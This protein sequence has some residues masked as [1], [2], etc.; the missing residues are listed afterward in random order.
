MRIDAAAAALEE[1]QSRILEMIATGVPLSGVLHAIVQQIESAAPDMLA[2]IELLDEDGVHLR[3]GAA[4]RLPGAYCSAIDGMP[5]GP[6]AGSC[7]TAMQSAATVVVQDIDADPLW[8]D[9]RALARE[10]GLRACWSTPILDHQRRVLGSFAL[11]FRKPGKPAKRHLRLIERATHL[12]AIALANG[13]AERERARLARELGEREGMF[14]SVFENS[15]VGVTVVDMHGTLRHCNP[16]FARMLGRPQ[17]ELVGRS[18]SEFTHAD[19][20]EPNMRLYRAL[21]AGEIAHFRMQKRYVRKD[22]ELVWVQ[23]NVSRVPAQGETPEQLTIGMMEDITARKRAEESLRD[24]EHRFRTLAEYSPDAIL[25]HQDFRIVF[26]NRA[27]VDLMRAPNAAALVGRPSTFMLPPGYEEAARL[28]S[29]ALYAGEAQPRAEQVY[30]R[31][32]GS[33]VEVEI[34]AAPVVVEGRPAAQ[35]TARDITGRKRAEADLRES[36]SRFRGILDGMTVGFVSLDRDWRFTYVNPRAAE[37]LRR[38]A[39]SLLGRPYLQAFPEARDSP[40]ELAYRRV[41]EERITLQHADFFPPWQR[42]FEQRVD[43]TAEGISVFFQDVTERKKSEARVEYLATHDGLTELPNRNLIHDRITQAIAHARRSER[44]IAVLYLDLDRFKVIND[45]F[46][47]PFGDAVLKAA[48]ERLAGVVRDGDTVARQ[49]GDEFLLLLADLRRSTDVYIVA[50]KILE[51]FAQP[52]VLQ[53]RE[54]HLSFSIGVSLFPQDGQTADALIG[55]ADVAMYRAKDSGR[56]VYQF[57]TREMSDETQRRVEIETE[58][59]AAVAR[60]QLRLVYQP[61][62]D[63]ASG[64]VTGCE[65]LLRWDHP[66]LG[67]VAPARFI[68]IAEDSGLIVPVG[69]WVLRTACEQN[70]AWQNAGLPPLVMSVNLSARQFLQ[71]DVVAWVQGVLRQTGLPAGSLELELTESLIAQDVEK[72]IVTVGRLKDAGV[73]LAIDDFGTG[74][75]SLSYLKRFRV[76]TLKI[77]QSF[78]RNLAS[79]VD[80][81]TIALAV[82]SLAHN[83]RMTAVAEGVETEAQCTFLRLNRC[84]AMQGYLFSKPLPPAELE[85]LLKSGRT[86]EL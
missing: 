53:G 13:R 43:P 42:W 26:V 81:A 47:H 79:E 54:V 76:D 35:V 49:G 65:A 27:M 18:F 19:D 41:M 9:Y 40:F 29:A 69:D 71:Q 14:R 36:E 39:Q 78:V 11:Y 45:G 10:H 24:S 48:G 70:R 74:Y 20:I 1:G 60:G 37:I 5:I 67:P 59:R 12:A 58:L 23:L 77:D 3:H 30:L 85:A 68:P 82:I 55:N 83:L 80:D 50:Q 32:D 72:F 73:R 4:G 17:A 63:L 51:A 16:A 84:D 8:A 2:S 75:S 6:R 15:A 57:F 86:L 34:A 31:L 61:R 22:G 25:I 33:P 64:R 28:R 46:G 56:N 38:D 52:I 66:T 62:V 7:G 21:A 44:Q